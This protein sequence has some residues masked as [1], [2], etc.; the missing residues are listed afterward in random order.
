[1]DGITMLPQENPSLRM[2]NILTMAV[3]LVARRFGCYWELNLQ[4][5]DSNCDGMLDFDEFSEGITMCQLDHLFP[6]SLQRTLFDKIDIDKVCR[7]T[8]EHI[9]CRKTEG[10]CAQGHS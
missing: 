8:K 10:E 5:Y 7:L 1:M 6:R 4:L 3:L 2:F 9:S